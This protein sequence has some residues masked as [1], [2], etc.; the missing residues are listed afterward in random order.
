VKPIPPGTGPHPSRLAVSEY[1]AGDGAPA[2]RAAFEAHISACPD[3]LAALR[4]A[5]SARDAFTARYPSLEYFRATRRAR[6]PAPPPGPLDRLKAWWSRP[7]A[8]PVFAA[9]LLLL[10]AAV[11]LTRLPRPAPDLSPKGTAKVVLAVNGKAVPGDTVRCRPGD[12]LQLGIVSDRPVHY[13]VLYRDD[14]GPLRAYMED[15]LAAPK[16]GPAGEDLPHSL[17]LDGGWAREILFCVWSFEP[18]DARAARARIEDGGGGLRLRAFVLL[19][20]P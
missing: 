8:R 13:A 12:T 2:D 11:V 16:G 5:E 3:C 6:R 17:V 19:N 7:A 10:L 15:G 1:L 9:A 4:E 14:E 18:F 20:V